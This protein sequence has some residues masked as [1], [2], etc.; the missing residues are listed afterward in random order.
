MGG[1]P[2]IKSMIFVVITMIPWGYPPPRR[3]L[4]PRRGD[5]FYR[6]VHKNNARWKNR[7]SEDLVIFM[8]KNNRNS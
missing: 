5:R 4:V 6:V 7:K 3:I 8:S 2:P 1:Y